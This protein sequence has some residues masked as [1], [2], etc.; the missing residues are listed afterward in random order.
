MIAKVISNDNKQDHRYD[1]TMLIENPNIR[2]SVAVGL[3]AIAKAMSE[4]IINKLNFEYYQL[5]VDCLQ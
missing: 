4:T 1:E 3:G 2:A 5:A